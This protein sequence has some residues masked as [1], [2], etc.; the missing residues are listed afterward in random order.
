MSNSEAVTP[1]PYDSEEDK[2]AVITT[3]NNLLEDPESDAKESD[4]DF[5]NFFKSVKGSAATLHKSSGGNSE[6]FP[7]INLGSLFDTDDEVL[8]RIF[9][10]AAVLAAFRRNTL[11]SVSGPLAILLALFYPIIY[12]GMV[13]ADM[14][15][16]GN[17]KFNGE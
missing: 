10:G 16:F 5:D 2:M 7:S 12:L 15:L 8:S 6:G 14:F 11:F 3:A 1:P 9:I 17:V 4:S 13:F